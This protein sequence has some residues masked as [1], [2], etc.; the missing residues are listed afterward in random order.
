MKILNRLKTDAKIII[1][2]LHNANDSL[3]DTVIEYQ[4]IIFEQREIIDCQKQEIE[5][6]QKLLEEKND[7]KEI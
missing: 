6:L 3:I 1:R 4:Q 7:F 2:D 5:R